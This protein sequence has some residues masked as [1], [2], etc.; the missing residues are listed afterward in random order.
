MN[1]HAEN[2]FSVQRPEV[3]SVPG[4]ERLAFEPDSCRQ[5]GLIF[6]RERKVEIRR[7]L[8]WGE[9]DAG[10][11]LLERLE[12]FGGLR[13]QVSPGLLGD[14]AV[15]PA[16]VPCVREKLQQKSNSSVSLRRGEE[17]VRVEK[18]PHPRESARSLV[19]PVQ[20]PSQIRLGLVEL[21]DT[22]FAV[23]LDG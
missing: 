9:L 18:D 23:D 12:T 21:T 2:C 19:A 15:R 8:K 17:N 1:R 22:L 4:D 7:R 5:N 16:L 6:V 3:R 14:V 11:G 13:D 20:R 10:Q